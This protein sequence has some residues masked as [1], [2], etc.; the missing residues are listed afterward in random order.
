MYVRENRL[1]ISRETNAMDRL[2]QMT[3]G[4]AVRKFPTIRQIDQYNEKIT[5]LKAKAYRM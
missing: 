5:A 4:V 2:Y 3:D 1:K